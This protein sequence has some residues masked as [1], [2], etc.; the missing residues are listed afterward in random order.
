[1]PLS[2]HKIKH[3]MLLPVIHRVDRRLSGWLATFLSWGGHLT[4]INSVLASIPSYFMTCFPW[5]KEPLSKLEGLLRAFFW[6]GKNKIKGGQC[7]VAWDKVVLPVLMEVWA[8]EIYTLIMRLCLASLW[9]KFFNP[10]TFLATAGLHLSTARL[11]YLW[12]ATTRIRPY[13][14][15]LKAAF[16]WSCLPLV[17]LLALVPMSPFGMN[18][19]WKLAG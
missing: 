3:G 10:Q 14:R 12:A 4:L 6:Q 7:L 8:L 5:P 16:L 9:Q 19:D 11:S 17:A 18:S 1:M 15:V 2:L 13:G